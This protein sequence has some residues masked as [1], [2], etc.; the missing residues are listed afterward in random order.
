MTK[1]CEMWFEKLKNTFS[2]TVWRIYFSQQQK[3][4]KKEN[5]GN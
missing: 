4:K 5:L 3:N 1:G 2:L